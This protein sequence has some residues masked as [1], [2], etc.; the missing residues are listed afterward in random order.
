[1]TSTPTST[2]ARRRPP[3]A[4]LATLAALAIMVAGLGACTFGADVGSLVVSAT[5]PGE[6]WTVVSF[7]SGSTDIQE[8][9]V[10]GTDA[11]AVDAQ[12]SFEAI[13]PSVGADAVTARV[14]AGTTLTFGA[15]VSDGAA[16]RLPLSLAFGAPAEEPPRVVRLGVALPHDRG[17]S[18]DVLDTEVFVTGVAGPVAVATSNAGVSVDV[19]ASGQ[20]DVST[21]NGDVSAS[22]GGGAVTTS[23]G[24]VDVVWTGARALT[25]RTSNAQVAVLVPADAGITLDFATSNDELVLFGQ[26]TH[27]GTGTQELN[28]G[29]P[30]LKVVTSNGPIIIRAQ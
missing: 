29:G 9:H 27:Q 10:T 4:A 13:V 19:I 2:A 6:G 11:G 1:M 7:A 30:V 5:G 21:T 24:D 17:V 25:V 22:G 15:P 28:G 12:A 23:N 18:V 20:L 14:L 26:R 3:L 16:T 8:V